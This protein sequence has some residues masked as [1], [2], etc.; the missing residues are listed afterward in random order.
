MVLVMAPG[1]LTGG[2]GH[3][4]SQNYKILFLI[5]LE[6]MLML[7]NLAMY[8]FWPEDLVGTDNYFPQRRCSIPYG[9]SILLPVLNCQ[10]NFIENPGLKSEQV[11]GRGFG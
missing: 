5:N 6:F 8:G 4:L 11:T 9:R 7:V 3:L 2:G 10:V 1:Q